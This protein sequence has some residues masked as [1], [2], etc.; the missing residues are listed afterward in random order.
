[1][2]P[3][4]LWAARIEYAIVPFAASSRLAAQDSASSVP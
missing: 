1:M 3:D 2:L 4:V